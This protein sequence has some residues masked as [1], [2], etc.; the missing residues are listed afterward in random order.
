MIAVSELSFAYSTPESF[1]SIK[2]HPED[3]IVEEKLH[4]ELE[5]EGEHLY[6]Y[7]EKVGL[8]TE[9]LVKE[10]AKSICK[11]IK[12]IAYAGL[13]DRH[14]KTRQWLSVHCPGEQLPDVDTLHGHGWHVMETARHRKKLKRGALSENSF[15]ILLRNVDFPDDIEKRLHL[16]KQSA[17]PNYFGPQRFGHQGQNVLKAK[18]ILLD[19]D[20][21]KNR[22]L[23]GMY[24]SAARSYLF[25]L[26]ICKRVQLDNWNQAVS[27]DV[28][29]LNGTNSIFTIDSADEV[30]QNRVLKQDI[31]PAAPLWGVGE[32]KAKNEALCIQQSAL[33]SY[34]PWQHALEQKKLQKSYRPLVLPVK[35]LC[36]QWQSK[37][38]LIL[39]FKLPSGAYAT[40]VLRELIQVREG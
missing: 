36:W 29:Q 1:G 24:L 16:I 19:G 15:T 13:K 34:E 17:V 32:E 3:F 39:Q 20:K 18:K 31:F 40:S 2:E 12:S 28:M 30:I 27:G 4:F 38:E 14:A 22:F 26:I 6:L 8:N 11:P 25:N 23:R 33:E 5:G 10:V 35:D 21:V 37:N 7:I 9:E